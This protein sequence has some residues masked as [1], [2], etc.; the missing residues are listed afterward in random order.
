MFNSAWVRS[1]GERT[2]E[3]L[4]L[5]SLPETDGRINNFRTF[6]LMCL[7]GSIPAEIFILLPNQKNKAGF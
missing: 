4:L 3:G 5:Q 1:L 6:S 7:P 2:R